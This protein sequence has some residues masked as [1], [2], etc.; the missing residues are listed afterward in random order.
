MNAKCT[1]GCDRGICI[2][3]DADY[4]DDLEA[5]IKRL[6]QFISNGYKEGY[7]HIDPIDRSDPAFETFKNIFGDKEAEIIARD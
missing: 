4:I 2:D 5:N 7:I 6:I 1:C 3:C